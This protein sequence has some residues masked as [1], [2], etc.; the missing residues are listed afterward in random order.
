MHIATQPW[1]DHWK[2]NWHFYFTSL[3]ERLVNFLP[4][5]D[6]CIIKA[7]NMKIMCGFCDLDTI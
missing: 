5:K 4:L 2:T 3:E 1:G 6:I 7:Q